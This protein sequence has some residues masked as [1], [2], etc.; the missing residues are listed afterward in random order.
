MS[1]LPDIKDV[2]SEEDYEDKDIDEDKDRDDEDDFNLDILY[3]YDDS[4]KCDIYGDPEYMSGGNKICDTGLD[5]IHRFILYSF[6]KPKIIK[7][8]NQIKNLKEEINK[9]TYDGWSALM[10]AC[11]NN[12]GH[13][14]TVKILIENGAN[15]DMQNK[16]GMTALMYAISYSRYNIELLLDS[17]ANPDLI[18]NDGETALL[19]DSFSRDGSNTYTIELFL[20]AK[21]D[22]NYQGG[23]KNR[24]ILMNNIYE[25]NIDCV[26]LLI[27]SKVDL[28]LED[29][30]SFNALDII[31]HSISREIRLFDRNY[32]DLE[33]EKTLFKMLVYAKADISC[34]ST[35]ELD[36]ELIELLLEN[37]Y[38]NKNNPFI[39]FYQKKLQEKDKLIELLISDGR[40][41]VIAL[42]GQ[43]L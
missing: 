3:G 38:S 15:L 20:K 27:E 28:D 22:L 13:H 26:K 7:K 33:C 29:E 6:Y 9:V 34:V 4:E 2:V 21:A 24:N 17:K 40:L 23:K 30:N 35:K 12:R 43:Y 10:I 8:I 42:V 5:V 39:S 18:N 19:M 14:D 37:G 11:L 1:D 16:F 41:P 36:N 32:G 31:Q 25:K